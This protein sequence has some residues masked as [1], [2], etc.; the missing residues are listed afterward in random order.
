MS[1]CTVIARAPAA[2]SSK[3]SARSPP[4]PLLL[5]SGPYAPV[6]P[7][8]LF[9]SKECKP[10]IERPICA[11]YLNASCASHIRHLDDLPPCSASLIK[12]S[13][14]PMSPPRPPS[15][16]KVAPLSPAIGFCPT[17]PINAQN[18]VSCP[19]LRIMSRNFFFH[20]FAFISIAVRRFPRRFSNS[21]LSRPRLIQPSVPC[22]ALATRTP[23][24]GHIAP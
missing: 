17:S 10:E 6:A 1:L 15:S 14:A 11:V 23:E 16:P 13:R 8:N 18:S 2:S 5:C 4:P 20:V 9:I 22:S 12:M 21:S 3:C 19:A 7:V 24:S